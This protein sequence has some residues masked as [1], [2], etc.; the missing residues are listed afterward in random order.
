MKEWGSP[1]YICLCVIEEEQDEKAADKLLF[2]YLT[3]VIKLT[4]DCSLLEL[5]KPQDTL[6][7]ILGHV[8][9]NLCFPRCWVW[10]TA[11]Q[12][13]S[14]LFAAFRLDQLSARWRE[15]TTEEGSANNTTP[16]PVATTFLTTNL[17]KNLQSKYLDTSTGEQV[18]T[19]PLL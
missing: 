6:T 11:S 8:G 16:E 1:L 5:S 19:A 14:Q 15:D 18:K 9:T 2:S 3:L 12:L 13:F 17:D 4:K 7:N 10:L